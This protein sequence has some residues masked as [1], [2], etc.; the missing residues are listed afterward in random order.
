[1]IPSL[2]TIEKLRNKAVLEE[3]EIQFIEQMY[4]RYRI[5]LGGSRLRCNKGVVQGPV[6]S[7]SLFDIYIEDLCNE[8]L[9][10]S[11]TSEDILYYADEIII[12]CTTPTQVKLLMLLKLGV[13]QVANRMLLNKNKSGIV[14]FG[15]RK[16]KKIPKMQTQTEGKKQEKREA[17]A[18]FD[19]RGTY[20]LKIQ[21]L[22]N[23]A[24]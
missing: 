4:A 3:E 9:K 24:R 11:V 22:R 1:M 14:I 19:P 20:L 15:D 8:I 18:Y 5:K 16:A 10:T 23:L 17:M 21:I 7:P 6:I 2:K 13:L 12:L